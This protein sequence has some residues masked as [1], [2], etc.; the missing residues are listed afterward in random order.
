MGLGLI[1]YMT[2]KGF[3]KLAAISEG[4]PFLFD[5]HAREASI[6]NGIHFVYRKVKGY[7]FYRMFTEPELA[8]TMARFGFGK[9]ELI[10]RGPLR[11]VRSLQSAAAGVPGAALGAR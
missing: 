6:F 9:Y 4:K 10:R 3:E 2:D 5:D 11:L 1:P 7:P 8:E